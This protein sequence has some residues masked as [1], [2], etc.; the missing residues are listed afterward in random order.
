MILFYVPLVPGLRPAAPEPIGVVLPKL[1][2]PLAYRFVGHVNAS[3][4]QEFLHVAV[5]QGEA[6]VESDT[7]AN[8]FAG[9]AVV[10]IAR[11]VGRRGHTWMPIL[12]FFD[13]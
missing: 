3:F 9:K 10:L 7:V 4:E 11:G 8:D 5:A 12:G 2:T 6:I 13:H 1:P